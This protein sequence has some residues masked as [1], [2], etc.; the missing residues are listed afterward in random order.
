V[1]DQVEHFEPYGFTSHPLPGAEA[2]LLSLNGRR[3]HT[4]AGVVTDRRHR[5]T[6]LAPGEA[7]LYS[8]EGDYVHLK[9]GRI[10]EVLAGAKVKVTAPEA[11]VIAS[12]KVSL[13][14]PL[15]ELSG[16]LVVAGLITGAA[17]LSISGGSGAQISGDVTVNGGDVAADGIALKA[18]VH[19]GVEP[20]AGTTGP[21]Q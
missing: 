9:N 12:T 8:H 13:T 15:T 4:L 19:G 5:K 11:E 10:I 7:A 16:N 17:G 3:S 1:L 14:T 2:L 18:H 20:G 21:A 6:G